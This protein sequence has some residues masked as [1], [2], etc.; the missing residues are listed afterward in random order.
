MNDPELTRLAPRN[1]PRKLPP[2][3]HID[4]S[5]RPEPKVGAQ[6]IHVRLSG[7]WLVRWRMMKAVEPELNDSDLL[8]ELLSA[9]F[10]VASVDESGQ[11]VE[12]ILRAKD[13]NGRQ[14]SD[15]DLVE[16]YGLET[17]IS[18]REAK[19]KNKIAA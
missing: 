14:L 4:F 19:R 5:P 15:V 16:Y 17:I 11:P 7:Q 3:L 8:R 6:M 1:D 13:Q 9:A 12:V 2:N 18:W 10:L